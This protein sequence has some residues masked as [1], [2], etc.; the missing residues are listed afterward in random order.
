MNAACSDLNGSHERLREACEKL[1]FDF[2]HDHPQFRPRRYPPETRRVHG[3]RRR[4]PAP[5]SR[6][7]RPISSTPRRTGPRSSRAVR[8][9]GSLSRTAA[10]PGSRPRGP[11][12]RRPPATARRTKLTVRAPIVVVA[13]GSI[14]SPALLLRSGIGGPAVGDF[15]RLHPTVVV[16][17]YYDEPQDWMTGPPQ[18]ALSHQFA[19]IGEGYGFL[20]ECAQA[21]TGLF[22]GRDPVAVRRRPQAP[23]ARVGARRAAR[24]PL[25]ARARSRPGR[26]STPAGNADRPLSDRRRARPRAP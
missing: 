23:H 24:S 15:L 14:H 18:A 2:R 8:F 7:P 9:S 10:P 25:V 3:F 20:I 1:G 26:R 12:R 5:S 16:T 17:A 6:R 11:T 4:R 19:D 21:T 13:C 22:G